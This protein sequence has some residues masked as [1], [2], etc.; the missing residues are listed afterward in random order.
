MYQSPSFSLWWIAGILSHKTFKLNPC[1]WTFMVCHTDYVWQIGTQ[2]TNQ[3]REFC[4]RYDYYY[5]CCCCCFLGVFFGF[6]SSWLLVPWI[7]IFMPPL[8][9]TWG[10]GNSLIE[11]RTKLSGWKLHVGCTQSMRSDWSPCW[12]LLIAYN[13]DINLK[14]LLALLKMENYKYG[15]RFTL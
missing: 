13:C 12:L 2:R 1:N 7:K 8:L 11:F 10:S 3:S 5:Y 15:N 14:M 9:V 6:I 4:C